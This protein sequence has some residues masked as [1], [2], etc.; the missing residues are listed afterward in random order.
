VANVTPLKKKK[1]APR[2]RGAR[3]GRAVGIA[4]GAVIAAVVALSIYFSLYTEWLWFGEVGYRQV[5]WTQLEWRL[6]TGLAFGALFCVLFYVNSRIVVRLAPTHRV[7][8]GVDVIEE[9][10]PRVAHMVRRVGLILALVIGLF[11]GLGAS[12]DWLDVQRLLHAAPWGVQDPIFHHD[13]SFYVFKLPF[14]HDVYSLLTGALVA[15]LLFALAAYVAL[16]NLVTVTMSPPGA[17]TDAQGNPLLRR[18][19]VPRTIAVRP[20]GRAV[21]HVSALLGALF[22]VGAV[23]SLFRAWDLLYSHA[24]VVAGAGYTDVHARLP[25]TR[26]TLVCALALAAMLFVNVWR[27]R[28]R[29]PL[30]AV[31]GWIVLLIVVRGVW[32]GLVQSLVVNPNQQEKEQQYIAYNVAATRNAYRLDAVKVQEYPLVGDLTTAKLQANDVTLRNIRLWDPRTLLTSYRQL[33]ELRPYYDFKDV[34]VDRYTVN[35]VYRETMLSARE[36]NIDRLP[37][38]AQTWVNQHITY[39][40]GFGVVVSAVNQVTPDGSP[41]F[42]VKDI[43]PVSQGNLTVDQPR[44]YYGE[45]GTDY[46]LVKTSAPE[47]DYP[48][49]GGDVFT[50]YQGSGGI[51]IGSGWRR[52]A[53][54]FRFGTIKFLTT[55]YID[56]DSRIIVRNNIKDRLAAAA[57][58]LRFDGDPY[59]VVA[60]G[61]LYWVADAYTTTARVPYSQPE[62]GINYMRNSVKAVIDAYDGTMRFYVFDEGDP[63]L[64]TYRGIFPDMFVPADEIPTALQAHIRYPEDFFNTQT[65]VFATYHVTEPDVLY[66]KG[67]QWQI[68][69]NVSLSGSGPMEGYYVIMRVPGAAKEQF[70]LMLPFVPNGKSNMVAWLGAICDV[71]DYG[72]ALNFSFPRSVQVYGPSQVEGAINQDT[73][74]SAQFTLWGTQGSQ[75]IMG[76]L[77][78]MPIEDSLLYVQPVY[79]QASK[80]AL[81][82]LKRVIVFYRATTPEGQAVL[83]GKSQ[84]VV[85]EPTLADSLAAIFGTAPPAA[86]RPTGGG[87]GAA[88][89]GTAGGT[90]GTGGGQAGGQTPAGAAALI[91]QANRQFEAAQSAQKRGDWAEYGRQIDA[92]GATLRQLSQTR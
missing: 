7:F 53:Y 38:N 64:K 34:D 25:G 49:G 17:E 85:M 76:N 15:C 58:F 46:T 83:N 29:W 18:S 60:D 78:V 47:F 45:M 27:R 14:W 65:A 39:T 23:G 35:G 86:G 2:S 22:A 31:A 88:T 19:P 52:L 4:V 61:R 80:T 8:E 54:A 67:D 79:L 10:S 71:P 56:S 82:Q 63:I 81:P 73:E 69:D 87:T 28:W 41:D 26:V 62:G 30:F 68:P 32:P 59:M 1:R 66:N 13:Y 44:I 20:E 57:P 77:L 90:G 72:H 51:P 36:L 11:V 74:I 24:G 16:G 89:G 48:G 70:L 75:V 33:Q 12:G 9:V 3:T 40:H 42:L 37:D 50:E 84:L 6:I 43:P 91:Q 55:G 92:L 5:F 21:A